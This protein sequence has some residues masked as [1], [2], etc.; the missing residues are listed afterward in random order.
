[1]VSRSLM[2][3]LTLIE[4]LVTM[5]IFA[6]LLMVSVPLTRAWVANAHISQTESLVRLGYTRARALALR[7]PLGVTASATA[8]TLV[9]GSY[10]VFVIQGNGG[11]QIWSG[12]F[13]SDTTV[14]FAGT[15]CNSQ[16]ALDNNG[17]P[18]NPVCMGYNISAS[19]GVS[20]NGTF[21]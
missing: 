1:M 12:T 7:N 10:S 6:I 20:V 2:A 15:G 13:N 4:L 9:I 5:S 16:L 11:S 21:Y 19:G 18:L 8:A 3:G 17:L 14:S